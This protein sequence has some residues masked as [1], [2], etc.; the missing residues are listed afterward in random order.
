MTDSLEDFYKEYNVN[1][2]TLFGVIILIYLSIFSLFNN[3]SLNTPEARPWIAMIEILLWNFH[4][5]FANIIET[6]Y[7]LHRKAEYLKWHS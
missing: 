3:I 4:K 5:I 7:F 2:L 1:L 6:P